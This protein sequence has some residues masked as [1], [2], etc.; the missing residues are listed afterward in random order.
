MFM[1]SLTEL[2]FQNQNKTTKQNFLDIL[3]IKYVVK[4][5]G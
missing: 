1:K 2:Q 5:A 4:A 3:F